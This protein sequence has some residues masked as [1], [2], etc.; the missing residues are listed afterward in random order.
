MA[1]RLSH[2]RSDPGV[3]KSAVD[4]VTFPAGCPN[5]CRDAGVSVTMVQP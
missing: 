5:A 2:E 4:A 1:E 3:M